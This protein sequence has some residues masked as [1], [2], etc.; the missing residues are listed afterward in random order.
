MR[1]P[2][3]CGID[4]F[5]RSLNYNE[6]KIGTVLKTFNAGCFFKE[7]LEKLIMAAKRTAF[8]CQELIDWRNLKLL[9]EAAAAKEEDTDM[10]AMHWE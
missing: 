8:V 9:V 4:E 5:V 10:A 6:Q 3:F 2:E 7:D 1:I